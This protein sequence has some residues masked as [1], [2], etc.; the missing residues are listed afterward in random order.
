MKKKVCN[1]YV[2]LWADLLW[3]SEERISKL[4]NLQWFRRKPWVFLSEAWTVKPI[5]IFYAAVV[6]LMKVGIINSANRGLALK[7]CLQLPV[8]K[9]NTNVVVDF[10]ARYLNPVRKLLAISLYHI[11][12]FYN[13][14]KSNVPFHWVESSCCNFIIVSKSKWELY[15]T[16]ASL[17]IKCQM[18]TTESN[19]VN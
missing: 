17:I 6:M 18:D 10:V 5:L 12:Q 14:D 9:M 16:Q 19:M 3:D 8:I 1:Y 11:I 7:C 13:I 15:C 4:R 2:L